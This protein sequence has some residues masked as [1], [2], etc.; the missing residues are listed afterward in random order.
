MFTFLE[1][2]KKHIDQME[3]EFEH[4]VVSSQQMNG[5]LANYEATLLEHYASQAINN[6]SRR[7]SKVTHVETARQTDHYLIFDPEENADV[8]GELENLPAKM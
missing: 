6:S 1:A 7:N 4:A 3:L 2:F 8:R 5:M